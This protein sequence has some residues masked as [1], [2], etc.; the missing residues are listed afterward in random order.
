MRGSSPRKACRGKWLRYGLRKSL[1]NDDT[2]M[3]HTISPQARGLADSP[4]AL[5]RMTRRR[6]LQISGLGMFGLGLPQLLRADD[7]RGRRARARS[8]IFLHQFGGPS[9]LDTFDMKPD[10]P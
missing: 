4:A 2:P 6:L 5:A 1:I 10:A 3:T 9:H 8:V 7:A